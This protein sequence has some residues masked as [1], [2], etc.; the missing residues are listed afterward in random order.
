MG[1]DE[2]WRAPVA[3]APV[4]GVVSVPGSKSA[5]NRA[6]VL[7]ALADGPS[8][9]R[10]PLLARD[11]RLM[12]GALRSLGTR[13]D[14]VPS[15]DGV[16]WMVTP[17]LLRGPAVIDCGLA[18]TVMRF[19]PVIAALA[20]GPVTF[21][22]D[23]RARVRPMRTIIE[24]LRALG[25]VVDDNDRGTMP[26]TVHGTGSV[27]V[28]HVVVDAS[29]SS[30]FV[31]ALMLAAPR[32]D[33]G[34][35][36][37]HRGAAIPSMPHLEMSVAMLRER[38]V[39]VDVDA[40]DPTNARWTVHPGEITGMDTTIE[41][42]LSNAAPF[43]AAAMVTGGSVGI[44]DW[45]T[46]TT[47]PGDRLREIFTLMGGEVHLVDGVCTVTGP[48]QLRGIDID[49]R[50]VGELT[51]VVAAV[52]ALASTP[53]RLRGIAHLRGHETDRLAALVTEINRVG[54][55][56]TETE[57]GLVIE[58]SDNWRAAEFATYE[59]HRMATAGAVLGLRIP[60]I[61]V[62]DIAT[63][64]KTLPDFPAMWNALLAGR[65]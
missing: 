16:G 41:P 22:G 47:Q 49:L 13:I 64:A 19:V 46:T 2:L 52:C 29:A 8:H 36:I 62:V 63:T 18:G 9:L 6:L 26:F 23:G 20:E 25:V 45:P 1:K 40:A 60:G 24:A 37:E 59:D 11:T 43:L 38:G 54:G 21:D 61:D 3:S 42:D 15:P 39:T 30:Q 44:R 48:L 51:P 27:A 5:T 35:T 57:D 32:F 34:C 65:E 14:E 31:S 50:D 56:A 28:D 12:A 17:R 55:R 7:A 4:R 10:K 53:S 58:P 33:N